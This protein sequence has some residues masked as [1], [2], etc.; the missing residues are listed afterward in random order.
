MSVFTR[1]N[2]APPQE[3]DYKKYHRYVREDFR[4]CCAYCLLHEVLAAGAENFELDHFRPKSLPEFADHV[5]DFYNIYYS[6]HVCNH[7][8]WRKWPSDELTA[9]GY[10]FI[11][12]CVENFTEH[13]QEEVDG[14]WTPL[15]KPGEYTEGRL[16]LNR[17]HL[18]ELR[19]LLREIAVLR[20][21][22]P[23]DWNSTC[24]ES[25]LKLIEPPEGE[26]SRLM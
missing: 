6:C 14:F 17:R 12:F 19:A 26:R 18:V 15:T 16:R 4:E 1:R 8:K 3:T 25:T 7:T 13:F 10:R 20:G 24:R 22:S 23:L 11:D 9:Q 21:L 5:N 2:P